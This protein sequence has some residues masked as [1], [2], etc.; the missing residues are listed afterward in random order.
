MAVES[1][2]LSSSSV[3]CNTVVVG[4]VLDS[5]LVLSAQTPT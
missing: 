1:V 4:A 2:G 3:L 5:Q